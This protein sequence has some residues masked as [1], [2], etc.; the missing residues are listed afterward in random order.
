MAEEAAYRYDVFISYSQQDA[1]WVLDWLLPRLKEAGLI[2]AIDEE[3]VRAG[4]PVLREIERLIDESRKIVAVL[5]PAYV[6]EG[7]AELETLLVQHR[8]PGARLR[9]LIPLG[10]EACE[11]P[12]RIALLGALEMSDPARRE[13]QL[14]RLVAAIRGTDSLPEVRYERIP[15]APQRWWELRWFALAGIASLL[16]LLLVAGWIW[17]QRPPPPPTAMPDGYN[18]AI[19]P[20][21]PDETTDADSAAEGRRRADEIA[22][23]LKLQIDDLSRVISRPV[24]VWGPVDGVPAISAGDVESRTLA[25]NANLLVYGNIER[26]TD[27]NWQLQP[28]FYLAD[29]A[30]QDVST[31]LAGELQGSYALGKVIRYSPSAELQGDANAEIQRRLEALRLLVRGFLYFSQ[32]SE[33]G[34]TKALREFEAATET[35]WG[36]AE[37]DTGQEI[38]Y[39]FLGNAHL[40]QL[41]FAVQ[42]NA[43]I[44][45]QR[46]IIFSALDGYEKAVELNG[47]YLRGVNGEA[48]GY[49][50]LARLAQVE[51]GSSC[52]WDWGWLDEAATLYQQVL[53]APTSQKT[54][55]DDV[56]LNAWLG[57]GRIRFTRSFCRNQDEWAGVRDAY[58]AAIALYAAEK[59]P[60]QAAKA[61]IAYRERGHTDFFQMD[62]RPQA[63][64]ERLSAVIGFYQESVAVGV[65]RNREQTLLMARDSM[66]YLLQALCRDEQVE[67]LAPTLNDF[68]THFSEPNPARDYIVKNAA[69]AGRQE[70]CYNAISQ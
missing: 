43:S 2:V 36:Q 66:I 11:P 51:S 52:G 3:S 49:V 34:Y 63:G 48:S 69:F 5:S 44:E 27:G 18:I 30:A 59:R 20:F 19:A 42:E 33:E 70:D 39:H 17:S 67:A 64:S 57:L 32:E 4:V 46:E 7:A 50:Q 8:D 28:A 62:D 15:D 6:S 47:E 25:L 24:N 38:L 26:A 12:G 1:P 13:S 22:G 54:P 31:E 16:T 29:T 9:R 55:G 53:D 60:S 56:D 35:E 37:D 21:A 40:Q 14:A 68:L 45:K 58:D 65:E 41:I 23:L 61:I 10:L